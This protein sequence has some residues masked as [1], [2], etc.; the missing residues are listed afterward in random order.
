[1]TFSDILYLASKSPRRRELLTQIGV[2][3]SII[4]VD[5]P[6]ERAPD[7]APL[8]YVSRLAA[9][10]ARAGAILKPDAPVLG[11]DT[12]VVLGS[13]V[14]EKPANK[15]QAINMLTNLSG[16]THQV[17]TAVSICRG[18]EQKTLCCETDVRFR[19]VSAAEAER[20]WNSGEPQDK[21]GGYGI[22]GLGGVFVEEIRG[23]YSAV[24]G[25]PLFETSQLLQ[26]FRLPVWNASEK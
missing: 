22:Q 6:E 20:Y 26:L 9:D 15:T 1:M 14:L 19:A 8:D 4:D 21:A 13:T 16:Q 25:L 18:S 11:A 17:M 24:V 2:V 10:K 23:S 3:F 7:E 5:V 12:I